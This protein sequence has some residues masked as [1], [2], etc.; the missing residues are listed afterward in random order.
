MPPASLVSHTK[1]PPDHLGQWLPRRVDGQLRAGAKNALGRS[2]AQRSWGAAVSR[3]P[4]P[5]P[6]VAT[7]AVPLQAMDVAQEEDLFRGRRGCERNITPSACPALAVSWQGPCSD[8]R[9]PSGLT[10]RLPR[11]VREKNWRN[12]QSDEALAE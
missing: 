6:C 2:L 11:A 5:T 12:R 10:A 1:P 9:S 4:C 7:C 3:V 8:E